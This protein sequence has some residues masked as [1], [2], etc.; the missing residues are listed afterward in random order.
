MTGAERTFHVAD[1][2][3]FFD[4]GW[5]QLDCPVVLVR[6]SVHTMRSHDAVEGGTS[7]L[8]AF[9]LEQ[10]TWKSHHNLHLTY[11]I[12]WFHVV[13][14]RLEISRNALLMNFRARSYC[15]RRQC[16]PACS[17]SFASWETAIGGIV[18]NIR[19]QRLVS[20][21][22]KQRYLFVSKTSR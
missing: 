20:D 15:V 7:G 13:Y 6:L 3:S 5:D 22:Y 2:R 1:Q 12:G 11:A 17:S 9:L 16:F 19:E 8:E 10:G 4:A 18:G 14:V 21:F